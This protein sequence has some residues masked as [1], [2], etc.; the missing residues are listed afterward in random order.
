[1]EKHHTA[2]RRYSDAAILLCRNCH[3]KLSDAQ[4]DHPKPVSDPLTSQESIGHILLGLADFFG[5][6]SERLR[7]FGRSLIAQAGREAKRART[8]R[9]G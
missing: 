1:L 5:E 4:K 8:G 7:E 3:R 6:L 2:G 9:H